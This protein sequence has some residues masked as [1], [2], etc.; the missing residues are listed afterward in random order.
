MPEQMSEEDLIN[1]L[2]IVQKS[3]RRFWP[4]LLRMKLINPGDAKDKR[5]AMLINDIYDIVDDLV[6]QLSP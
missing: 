1:E 2:R 5:M 6:L 4:I 3:I